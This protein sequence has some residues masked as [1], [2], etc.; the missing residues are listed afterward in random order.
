MT[1]TRIVLIAF[2]LFAAVVAQPRAATVPQSDAFRFAVIGD[3]GTGSS[4]QEQVAMELAKAW[5]RFRFGSV[6]MVGDNLYG[7]EAPKDFTKKFEQ[8]YRQLLGQ[9]VKFYAA[10]GNHDDAALQKAYKPFNMGGERFYSFKP[11]PGVRFFALDSNYVDRKQ[12]EWLEK[13][14]IASQSD[15]KILFFHHPLYSS[16]EKHGSNVELRKML[17]PMILIHGVDVVFTGHEHFY[18]RIKPQGGVHYFIVGSSAK[19]RKGNI[20]NTE[21]TAKGYDQDHT[22]LVAQIAGDEMTFQTISRKGKIVDSGTIRRAEKRIT[23]K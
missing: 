18:E 4:S 13:E 10:L 19:L 21:L 12:L 2:I 9:G 7:K 5:S 14:L 1:K 8:P 11:Q 17:E 6:L 3:T 23:R 15:W 22:F 16:G 20:A